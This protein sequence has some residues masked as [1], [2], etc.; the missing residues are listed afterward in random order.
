MM[1]LCFSY[2]YVFYWSNIRIFAYDPIL[3]KS[4]INSMTKLTGRNM[5]SRSWSSAMNS[6]PKSHVLRLKVI[7]V[8]IVRGTYKCPFC[9]RWIKVSNLITHCSNVH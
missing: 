1:Y 4:F 2:A 6:F 5:A 3:N 7:P 8:L 9:N